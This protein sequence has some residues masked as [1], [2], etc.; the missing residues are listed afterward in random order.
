MPGE[1]IGCIEPDLP[2]PTSAQPTPDGGELPSATGGRTL[3][4]R[5]SHR[6]WLLPVLAR[7]SGAHRLDQPGAL[8]YA[9]LRL[10]VAPAEV[11]GVASFYGMFSLR[12]RPPVV[13][14]V[15]DD[16]ACLTRGADALCAGTGNETRAAWDLLRRR[17]SDLAAQPVSWSVRTRA[18][19]AH[20]R[21]GR[22]T[23]AA[24]TCTGHARCRAESAARAFERPANPTYLRPIP[25]AGQPQ[26]RLLR[27]VGD[28]L[29]ARRLSPLGRL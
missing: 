17:A 28:D 15:C 4:A 26:L 10:D 22:N 12:P 9:A 16:I 8:N 19:G 29:E 1:L 27:R 2:T 14:H 11:H 25:Q 3:A 6:H 7:H 20:D 21:I 5:S 13:A 18:G 23:A 24:R